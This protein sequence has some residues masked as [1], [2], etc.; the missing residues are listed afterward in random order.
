MIYSIAVVVA[1]AILGGDDD[2]LLREA[3]ESA[4]L[5]PVDFPQY[6]DA[7]VVLRVVGYFGE[8][9]ED[10]A[11]AV[12]CFSVIVMLVA[13]LI[14]LHVSVVLR[15]PL[16]SIRRLAIVRPWHGRIPDRSYAVGL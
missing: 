8:G 1:A 7:P 11:L 3:V 13:S 4:G 10:V 5:L 12:V 6:V 14:T 15:F 16:E 9:I 2:E